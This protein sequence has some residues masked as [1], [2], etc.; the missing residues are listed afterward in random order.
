MIIFLNDDAAYRSWIGHHRAGFVL[1]GRRKPKVGHLIL[2]RA[3]CG[4]I[5]VHSPRQHSTT[6]SKLK[7]VSLD[8]G[9][10]IAWG[11]AETG[12]DVPGCS[13]CQ[14]EGNLP[15]SAASAGA[16]SKLARDVL[17]YVLEAALIHMENQQPP[18]RLS[19]GD[20]ADCF[21]KTSGQ[22]APVLG[23]LIDEGWLTLIGK[24]AATGKLRR[25]IVAPTIL[26]L[27][28]LA[29]F[30]DESDAAIASELE[31][32]EGDLPSRSPLGVGGKVA[33]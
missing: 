32:L 26:A 21:G 24:P 28:T 5:S 22:M 10:L 9:E 4:E 12:H 18:Y 33:V 8:R 13:A 16:L 25:G 23:R 1:D 29:A 14:A 3:T 20:I 7:A 17:D 30:Q 15:A 31:K 11:A 6:G 27:R 19:L 2:H